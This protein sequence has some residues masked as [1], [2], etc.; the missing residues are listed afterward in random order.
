MRIKVLKSK[1]HLATV[2]RSD[3]HYHGSLT[4]DPELMKAVGIVPYE[5]IL[6]SNVATGL[7]GETYTLPREPA[8]SPTRDAK[9]FGTLMNA[10]GRYDQPEVGYRVC[11]GDRDEY[12]A[13]ALRLL[14]G[15]RE[16]L[17]DSME[18]IAE[19][20]ITQMEALQYFHAADRIRD[21]VVGIAAGMALNREGATKDLPIIAFA[22][23]DDGIK[24]SARTT[25]ELVARGLDLAAIMQA[26]SMAVGGQGGGHHAAAGATIPPGTEDK[27]LEIANRMVREQLGRGGTPPAHSEDER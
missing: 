25:R 14:R 5:A 3:L 23:A 18:A 15:H 26:A 19:A 6:V 8:G 27:F 16:Y 9:E 12:L 7:R 2:T 20:G 1:L 4:I 10:C 24:V 21:T 17:V 13:Q 11:R 22:Q